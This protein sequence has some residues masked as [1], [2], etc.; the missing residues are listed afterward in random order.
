MH[1][2]L[3]SN[4]VSGFISQFWDQVAVLQSL[5]ANTTRK[6]ASTAT[7]WHAVTLI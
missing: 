6:F 5:D 2:P 4:D 7:S 1:L 3:W